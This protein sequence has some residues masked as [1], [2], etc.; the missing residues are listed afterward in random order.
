MFPD[1]KQEAMVA[2][3]AEEGERILQSLESLLTCWVE[4]TPAVWEEARGAI[5]EDLPT[6]QQ[7]S[8]DPTQT[9]ACV[10]QWNC[11]YKHKR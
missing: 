8:A 9:R 11:F 2:V 6:L 10:C 5:E 1:T 4:E 3:K 7:G